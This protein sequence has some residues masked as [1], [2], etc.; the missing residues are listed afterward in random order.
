MH[1]CASVFGEMNFVEAG[2]G[3]AEA[4]VCNVILGVFHDLEDYF[5]G[6]KV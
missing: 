3:Q 5:G 6:E 4:G 2:T 1:V